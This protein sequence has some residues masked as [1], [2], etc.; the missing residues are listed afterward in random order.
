MIDDPVQTMDEVNM[1]S[2]VQMMK[3]EFPELQI[4]LS[5]HESKVAN[6]FHYKYSQAGLKS[7]PINMKNKRLESIN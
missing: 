2:F 7:F 4:L 1:A 5:T 3:Y 6:Y